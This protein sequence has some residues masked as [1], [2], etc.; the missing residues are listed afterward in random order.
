[1]ASQANE[2]P[3]WNVAKRCLSEDP[4]QGKLGS[5]DNNATNNDNAKQK[6][7]KPRHTKKMKQTKAILMSEENTNND[8]TAAVVSK[9]HEI[10]TQ[11][12]VLPPAKPGKKAL[13]RLRYQ[14]REL[15][16]MEYLPLSAKYAAFTGSVHVVEKGAVCCDDPETSLEERSIQIRTCS[17]IPSSP[18]HPSSTE[19]SQDCAT[20]TTT[21]TTTIHV[22][23]LLILDLNGILCHRLRK[24]DIPFEHHARYRPSIG[25]FAN[26]DIIPRTDLKDFLEFLNRHFCLAVWTSAKAKT[27]Q[28]ILDILLLADEHDEDENEN[29]TANTIRNQLL[30]VLSQEQCQMK[31]VDVDKKSSDDSDDD[32]DDDEYPLMTIKDLAKVWADYPLWD[33]ETTLLMDDTPAKSGPWPENAIHPPSLNGLLVANNNVVDSVNERQQRVFLEDLVEHWKANTVETIWNNNSS[34][35]KAS[36][37]HNN[38]NNNNNNNTNNNGEPPRQSQLSFLRQHAAKHN[39]GW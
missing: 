33:A 29:R 9:R 34:G 28:K 20:T 27:A 7:K 8:D 24:R 2:V 5:M 21:T 23:P 3:A 10:I 6:K 22:Q 39:M 16:P 17:T 32:S 36:G 31:M 19:D 37:H 11:E 4:T 12:N 38:D 13:R 26:T 30:F 35:K 18:S 25:K 1:M 15:S 14:Q